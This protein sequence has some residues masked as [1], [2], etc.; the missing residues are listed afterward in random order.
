M[1]AAGDPGDGTVGNAKQQILIEPL[2][3]PPLPKCRLIRPQEVAMAAAEL[4]PFIDQPP[5]YGSQ[6]RQPFGHGPEQLVR[7]P[8]PGLLQPAEQQYVTG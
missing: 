6:H 7:Q 8:A 5:G 1:G 2:A 3:P 4:K